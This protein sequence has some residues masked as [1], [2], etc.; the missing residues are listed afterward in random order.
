MHKSV[1][2]KVESSAASFS[3]ALLERRDDTA[4]GRHGLFAA[5]VPRMTIVQ[6]GAVAVV[7]VGGE[8][9]AWRQADA[10]GQC[11]LE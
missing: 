3:C 1:S 9:W 10:L 7:A 4:E 8:D 5:R 11:M 6:A 2:V